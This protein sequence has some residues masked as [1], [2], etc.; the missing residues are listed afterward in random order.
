MPHDSHNLPTVDID[1]RNT[2]T[3]FHAAPEQRALAV[4]HFEPSCAEH[5]RAFVMRSA[6]GPRKL[7]DPRA[8]RAHIERAQ[9]PRLALRR[10]QRLEFA[11]GVGTEQFAAIEH[12]V[13]VHEIGAPCQPVFGDH[14]RHPVGFQRGDHAVQARHRRGVEVARRLVE[15][16]HRRFEHSRGRHGEPLLLA[17]RQVNDRAVEQVGNPEARRHLLH[18]FAD[19]RRGHAGVFA[20]ECEFVGRPRVE[21]LGFGVLE[22]AAHHAR[23]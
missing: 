19:L 13:A 21:I 20:G 16:H 10:R 8:V 22:H 1:V 3:E 18:A 9:P 4:S 17:S 12:A 15:H 6:R 2:Q 5:R 7:G 23:V 11:R 14:N